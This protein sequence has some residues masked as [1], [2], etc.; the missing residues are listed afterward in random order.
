M[1]RDSEI[2]KTTVLGE[3]WSIELDYTEE[4]SLYAI[5][6]YGEDGT[7][8]TVSDPYELEVIGKNLMDI[9]KK[10]SLEV[11]KND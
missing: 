5:D 8:V 1:T 4:G 3:E 7:R 2:R 9:G 10:I 11:D 6:I